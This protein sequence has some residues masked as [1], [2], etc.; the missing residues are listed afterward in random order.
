MK[1][2]HE[3]CRCEGEEAFDGYCSTHCAAA[4]AK[5]AEDTGPCPCGHPP[6]GENRP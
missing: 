1:C 2:I 6:C 5:P 4:D 3:S